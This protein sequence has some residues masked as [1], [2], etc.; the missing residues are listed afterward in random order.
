MKKASTLNGA[1][2]IRQ[3]GSIAQQELFDLY[4][5][6]ILKSEKA[7]MSE[8]EICFMIEKYAKKIRSVILKSFKNYFLK[9]A[10]V[11]NCLR[12]RKLRSL[13]ESRQN[14]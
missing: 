14:R 10:F 6:L 4:N 12:F 8:V 1:N 11:L 5:K 9:C 2:L 7:G 3:N 13:W